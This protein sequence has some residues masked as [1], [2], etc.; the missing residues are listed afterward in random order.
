MAA[1]VVDASAFDARVNRGD[2][3]RTFFGKL[4]SSM[5]HMLAGIAIDLIGFS[6]GAKP[7]EV[8][9]TVIFR[10]GLLDGPIAAAPAVL[11]ILFYGGYR[12]DKR[13]HAE[14]RAKLSARATALAKP[15]A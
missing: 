9:P 3:A 13:R 10:L 14:T 8:D 15:I 6:P 2:A 5:G 12:I 7:G 4:T 11:S 1:F